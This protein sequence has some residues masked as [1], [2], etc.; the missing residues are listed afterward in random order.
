MY[1]ENTK[2]LPP[3]DVMQAFA[4]ILSEL[5]QTCRLTPPQPTSH[6]QVLFWAQRDIQSYLTRISRRLLLPGSGLNGIEQ[7]QR[8]IEL[9]DGGAS[10]VLCL[11][12]RSNLDVPTLCALLQDHAKPQ[13]FEKIIWIAGRKLQEDPGMTGILV[14]A[15]HRVIVTP[16]SWLRE[17]HSPEEIHEGNL[18]NIAAHREIHDLRHQGWVFALFPTGTRIRPGEI[19]TTRAIPETDSYLKSFEYM[20]LGNIAG[21]TLP[22]TRD[23]DLTHETPRLDRV[24]VNFG[25]VLSTDQW[26]REASHRYPELNQRAAA[27][28][29]IMQDIAAL[30]ASR[31]DDAELAGPN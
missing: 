26:R 29:A 28:R 17:D 22:V 9:A 14:Q 27:A 1:E 13:L 31:A 4:P 25:Q 15:F 30:A 10:C 21:C 16:R 3:G 11:N 12:H 7:L 5:Q 8:L 18:I 20:L 6:D 2:P 19:S 24:I 23:K